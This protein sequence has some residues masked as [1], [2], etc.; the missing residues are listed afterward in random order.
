MRDDV[1]SHDNEV[2][3]LS[4]I[5]ATLATSVLFRLLVGK[6]PSDSIQARNFFDFLLRAVL[7]GLGIPVNTR[8]QDAVELLRRIMG[9]VI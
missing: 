6:E 8:Y 3:A 2:N 1:I 4:F 5:N 7:R 9:S